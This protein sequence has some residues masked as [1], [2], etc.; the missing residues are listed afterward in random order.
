MQLGLAVI[1]HQLDLPSFK[2]APRTPQAKASVVVDLKRIGGRSHMRFVSNAMAQLVH[3]D[4]RA[5][6][7]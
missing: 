6:K 4:K 2:N 7:E 5:D 3:G 1:L